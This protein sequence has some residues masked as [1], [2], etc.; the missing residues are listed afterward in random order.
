MTEDSELK[1]NTYGIVDHSAA[2]FHR[3]FEPEKFGATTSRILV[4]AV[5]GH[6]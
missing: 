3:R 6:Y 4:G 1:Q 5:Y 2:E